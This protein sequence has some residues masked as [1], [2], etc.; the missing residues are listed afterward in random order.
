[1]VGSGECECVGHEGEKIWSNDSRVE[2][3][4]QK[5]RQ[6]VPLDFTAIADPQPPCRD[7]SHHEAVSFEKETKRST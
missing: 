1:M 6:A 3:R 5:I 2:M 7:L 4:E